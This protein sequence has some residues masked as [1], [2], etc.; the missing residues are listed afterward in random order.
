MEQ[1]ITNSKTI[2]KVEYT[3]ETQKLIITFT[4]GK[5]YEYSA[6]PFSVVREMLAADSVGSY[7]AQNIKG[8][9]NYR[10]L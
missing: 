7:F 6:V 3:E 10:Q 1:I 9:Y 8:V 2:S 4:T 5:R